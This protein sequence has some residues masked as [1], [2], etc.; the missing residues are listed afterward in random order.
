[1]VSSEPHTER[2]VLRKSSSAYSASLLTTR[3][4]WTLQEHSCL[5]TSSSMCTIWEACGKF[6]GHCFTY[7]LSFG[8]IYYYIVFHIVPEVESERG[9]KDQKVAEDKNSA[10]AFLV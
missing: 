5:D 7:A 9:S 8:T 3:R 10:Y 4:L 6:Q 2:V 1:M